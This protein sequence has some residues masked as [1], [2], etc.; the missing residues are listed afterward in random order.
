VKTLLFLSFLSVKLF[1]FSTAYVS[2]EIPDGWR[3]E[4]SQGVWICQ[5]LSDADRKESVVLSIATLATEWD[6]IENYEN[7]LK[8]PKT[9]Q[10]DQGNQIKSEVRYVRKRNINGQTWIDSLQFNSELSGFWARY[11]ATVHSNPKA[12]LAILIT[13]LVS[14]ERYKKLAPQFE[15]MI[16][17]MKLNEEFDL[18][19]ATRQGDLPLIGAE[20]IGPLQK[21]LIRDRLGKK[22]TDTKPVTAPESDNSALILIA[23]VAAAGLFIFFRRKQAKKNKNQLPP[24]E[25]PGPRT[26]AS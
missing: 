21:D 16:T 20:K 2:F 10:D 22:A 6:T 17:S 5:S 12:K 13:Y 3:C 19:V 8:E 1:A 26:K 15:R 14:D 18:N 7:Y 9:I 4:L 23:V 11:V 24:Q 25:P